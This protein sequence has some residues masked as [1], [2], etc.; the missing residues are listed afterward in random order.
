MTNVS[1]NQKYFHAEVSS[2]SFTRDWKL[3]DLHTNVFSSSIKTFIY[4][5]QNLTLFKTI[6]SS[7]IRGIWDIWWLTLACSDLTADCKNIA[8]FTVDGKYFGHVAVNC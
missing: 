3:K 5:Q 2:V 6:V 8:F 4:K 1:Q 7:L